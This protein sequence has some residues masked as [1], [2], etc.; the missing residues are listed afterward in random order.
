[1]AK[2]KLSGVRRKS[3]LSRI[4][5]RVRSVNCADLLEK[6]E[7]A[8]MAVKL[9]ADAI[10]FS[11]FPASEMAVLDKHNSARPDATLKVVA[12]N[13]DDDSSAKH[14]EFEMTEE[15]LQPKDWQGRRAIIRRDDPIFA[16][17]NAAQSAAEELESRVSLIM[18]DYRAVVANSGYF[19][20]VVA[21]IPEVAK[22]ENELYPPKGAIQV[23]NRE[24]VERVRQ[25]Q[26]R[27]AA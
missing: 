11:Q 8:A 18:G 7:E 9:R 25:D 10:Y 12:N 5:S 16:L 26:E 17:E 4:E 2:Q 15:R 13:P 24:I 19:E 1:M 3:I 23:L 21:L 27:L 14:D 22:F 6:S 20:D